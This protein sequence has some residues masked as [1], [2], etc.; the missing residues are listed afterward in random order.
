[1]TVTLNRYVPAAPED[2]NAGRN[3]TVVEAEW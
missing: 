2:F 1:M 3:G